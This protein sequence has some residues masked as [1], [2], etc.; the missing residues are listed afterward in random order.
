MEVVYEVRRVEGGEGDGVTALQ[1]IISEHSDYIESTTK[2]PVC[3]LTP[4]CDLSHV[5][6][7][8]EQKVCVCV[9][10]WVGGWVCACVWTHACVHTVAVNIKFMFRN[11]TTIVQRSFYGVKWLRR[12]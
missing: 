2:G 9:G 4:D 12:R 10:M 5:M 3:P 11:R 6:V 7:E 1:R 8:E